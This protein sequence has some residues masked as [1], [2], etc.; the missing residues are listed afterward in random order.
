MGL[1]LL[2]QG[3]QRQTLCAKAILTQGNKKVKTSYILLK[4]NKNC[5]GHLVL[6]NKRESAGTARDQ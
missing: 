2:A 4:Q 6:D 1:L 3:G 5:L